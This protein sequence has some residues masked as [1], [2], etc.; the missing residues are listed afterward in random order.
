M[1]V[2]PVQLHPVAFPVHVGLQPSRLLVPS[3]QVSNPVT[4]PSPHLLQV[5]GVVVVPPVQFQPVTFP[6]HVGLQP[7]K[8][9]AFPSSQVSGENTFP[10]PQIGVQTSFAG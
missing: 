7:T 9:A 1:V 6:L 3:S 8:S 2:P 10:S 5:E 4:F